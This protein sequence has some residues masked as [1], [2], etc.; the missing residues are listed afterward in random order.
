M[1]KKS[2]ID[3]DLLNNPVRIQ[4]TNGNVTKYVYSATGEKL[5][6]IYQTAV[7]N[8]SVAMGSSRELAPS[9]IQFADS[10]DYLLG[11]VLTMKN[12]RI[13][14]YLFGGGYA[15]ASVASSTT[16]NFAFYYYNQDHLGNVREVVDA[17]GAVKQVTN[18]YPFGAPY[19]DTS[20]T[21]NAEFQPYKY[22]GKELD[23][24]HGLDTYDY[25]ARQYNPV[26]ARWDRVDPLCEKY[27]SISPYAYCGNNPVNRV[28]KDGRLFDTFL[29][30]VFFFVRC[31]RCRIPVNFLWE[32]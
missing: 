18:Y 15:Q 3:Y 25:G 4:F 28:D 12:G 9:E 13:D 5:R 23:Q 26:L 7:P 14:K 31:G 20:A 10:T 30:G 2:K 24:M 22:N 11:G 6:V 32:C 17:S 8:I 29:D 16:D 27:Y 19:A 21:T 1:F